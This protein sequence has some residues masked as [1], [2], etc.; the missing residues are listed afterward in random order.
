M[1]FPLL[2]TS[3]VSGFMSQDV[4][5]PY[6]FIVSALQCDASGVFAGE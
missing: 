6:L 2:N 4:S 5:L 3:S 1:Y